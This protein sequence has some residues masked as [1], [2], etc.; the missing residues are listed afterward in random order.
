MAFN[1]KNIERLCAV[2]CAVIPQIECCMTGL[3]SEVKPHSHRIQHQR[4][5]HNKFIF[6]NYDIIDLKVN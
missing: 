4:G 5:S 2:M 3:E 6:L 1:L